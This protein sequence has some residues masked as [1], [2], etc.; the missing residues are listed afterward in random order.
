VANRREGEMATRVRGKRLSNL[1]RS[2]MIV[3]KRL[4]LVGIVIATLTSPSTAKE[5]ACETKGDKFSLLATGTGT[6]SGITGSDKGALFRLA[7]SGLS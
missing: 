7:K 4:V 2:E 3:A 1:R 6:G 5:W